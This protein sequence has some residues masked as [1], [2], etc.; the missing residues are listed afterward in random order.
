[1][2]FWNSASAAF[3]T[4]SY[5]YQTCER[6][7]N[8]KHTGGPDDTTDHVE[9]ASHVFT[10]CLLCKMLKTA[11]SITFII[12][13]GPW[14]LTDWG[15]HRTRNLFRTV[16]SY[17]ETGAVRLHYYGAH[18]LCLHENTLAITILSS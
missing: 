12:E 7:S 13:K 4:S 17:N 10:V 11:K 18:V 6:H 2:V 15:R 16:A 5:E 8:T 14:E 1:M 3:T 9:R